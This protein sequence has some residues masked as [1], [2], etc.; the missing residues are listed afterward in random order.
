MNPRELKLVATLGKIAEDVIPINRARI[1]AAIVYKNDIISLGTN[2]RKTHP[3]QAKFAKH[4]E[5][6]HIH[7][8]IDAIAR[9]VRR[10]DSKKLSS[11]T[12]YVARVKVGSDGNRMWGLAKPCDGCA[13]A[14]ASFDIGQ[15]VWT[16]DSSETVPD[17]MSSRFDT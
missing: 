7:A 3:L 1:A 8:E 9:A 16:V 14:I 10:I 12:L 5:A 4:W 2:Q 6:I 11:C 13:R 15:V 17:L